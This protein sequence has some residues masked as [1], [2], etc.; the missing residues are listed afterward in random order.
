MVR[1]DKPAWLSKPLDR[2]DGIRG[3]KVLINQPSGQTWWCGRCTVTV[4]QP[5]GQT[6][7]CGRMQCHG[8]PTL[9]TNLVVWVDALPLLTSNSPF[10][11]SHNVFL[12]I[13][14]HIS[15]ILLTDGMAHSDSCV[16][17]STIVIEWMTTDHVHLMHKIIHFQTFKTSCMC[18]L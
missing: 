9:W 13:L 3:Y 5:S 7:W 12:P 14:E 8:P 17:H 6:W 1:K 4:H 15:V 16:K 10:H 11:Y 18:V 2:I